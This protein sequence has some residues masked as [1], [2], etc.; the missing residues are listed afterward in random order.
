MSSRP[1][2]IILPVIN[3]LTG[4]QRLHRVALS[5][6]EAGYEVL[7]LGRRL[8]GSLP[9][10]RPYGW[11]RMRLWTRRGKL[12]YLEFTLRLT[13]ALLWRRADLLTANDLDTLL[14]CWLVS[15]LRGLPLLYD[16][17]EYF[18]EVPELVSRP[19]TR[20]WWLWLERRL[21]PRLRQAIT[22]NETLAQAY[23]GLYGVP[24]AVIRNMP[25]PQPPPPSGERP[26]VLLYQGA[27][28]L[29]RGID[30]MIGAMAHLPDYTLW[31]AGRGDV[32]ADLR[33]QAAGQDNVRFLG[34]LPP[35]ELARLTRQARLGFSLEADLGA[36]YRFASP[37]KVYDYI[38]AHTPVLV[39]DLPEM[40]RLVRDYGV[41]DILPAAERQ[42]A[43]LAARVRDLLETPGRY[44]AAV[45]ACR[46]AA[47]VLHWEAERPRLLAL[48]EAAF[49]AR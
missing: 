24:V 41:G 13:W 4:D 14:P 40:A 39:A 6:H 31:I 12:F 9:L 18:T 20:A 42:P 21:F 44:A 43:A 5:L 1:R 15:R 17:H 22:V 34:F 29:G 2:R 25:L 38:Q 35:A 45:E 23:A 11:H 7:I 30:L 16:S 27:L 26:R 46:Q 49:S 8:P 19:R 48:Y 3:D 10:D 28:N 33:A 36:N 37:N 47:Q 32:E